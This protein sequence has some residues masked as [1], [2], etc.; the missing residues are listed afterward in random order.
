MSVFFLIT[1]SPFHPNPI[2]FSNVKLKSIE[3]YTG[4]D[5]VLHILGAD[6]MGNTPIYVIKPYLSYT[7]SQPDAV[8]GFWLRLIPEELRE[9]LLC[10]LAQDHIPSYQDDP[11][12]IYGFEF[13]GLK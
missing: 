8:G 4:L 2:G 13:G 7:D 5:P 12:R 10:V 3:L 1:R 6:L 11:N 9:A